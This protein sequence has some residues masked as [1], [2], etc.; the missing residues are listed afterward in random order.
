MLEKKSFR[1]ASPC[2]AHDAEVMRAEHGDRWRNRD[3]PQETHGDSRQGRRNRYPFK[4]IG[5]RVGDLAGCR[6]AR[7]EGYEALIVPMIAREVGL[8]LAWQLEQS[9]G[10][11]N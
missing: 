2:I 7:C 11:S 5:I 6:I 9:E 8:V 1:Q 3:S 4:G 10:L